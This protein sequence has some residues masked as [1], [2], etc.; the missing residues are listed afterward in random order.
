[1][2][3]LR[4]FV[5][6]C[7][8]AIGPSAFNVFVTC[9]PTPPQTA[10]F[11]FNLPCSQF[12]IGSASWPC[13]G[14]SFSGHH[15]QSNPPRHHHRGWSSLNFCQP[16]AVELGMETPVSKTAAAIFNCAV[17]LYKES[18]WSYCTSPWSPYLSL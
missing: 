3:F 7:F 12:T 4:P 14:V 17:Q 5:L 9:A 16:V 6:L 10:L 8:A 15:P 18:S 1:M 11:F 2:L 13:Q